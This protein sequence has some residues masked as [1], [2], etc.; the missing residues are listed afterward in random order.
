MTGAAN[1]RESEM[2]LVESA[3]AQIKTYLPEGWTADPDLRVSSAEQPGLLDSGIAIRSA[4]GAWGTLVVE[5]KRSFGPRDAERLL[6][7]V[8]GKLRAL[9]GSVSVLVVAPWL[10]PRTQEL[11]VRQR[12]NFVDL[13]GNALIALDNPA[14]YVKTTGAARSPWPAARGRPTVRGPRAARLIRLLVDVR[15]PYGVGELASA[16]RLTPGYVSRLLDALDREALVERGARGRVEAVDVDGLVRRWAESYDVLETNE[17]RTFIAPA[18]VSRALDA[19]ADRTTAGRVAVT[20]SFGAVRLAPVAAPALLLAYCD[21]I[22][23]TAEGLGLLPADE[24]ADVALLRPFD[25]VVWERTV[26]EDGIDFVAPSQL[27][28]D[29]LTG[30]GRMPAE[31][32]ALLTMMI[33]DESSWRRVSLVEQGG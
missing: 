2:D 15:P 5:A 18:G 29:C 21:D 33:S 26:R 12:V 8:A 32:E 7:G 28:V 27:V 24:G 30:T 17:R 10:S 13:S 6:S 1:M 19:L 14:L 23:E 25:S 3:I 20:G 4:N 31:G 9:A 22:Q 16:A 11:L